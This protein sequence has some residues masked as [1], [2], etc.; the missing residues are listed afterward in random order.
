ML[1]FVWWVLLI[2]FVV[3]LLIGVMLYSFNPSP[4]EVPPNKD[5]LDTLLE[6]N[7]CVD[8]NLNNANLSGANLER[9]DLGHRMEYGWDDS[10][11]VITNLAGANLTG[12]NL[13]RADLTGA[14]LSE[15]KLSR[16][17][18]NEA[19]LGGADLTNANLNN[20]DLTY[21]KF[22]VAKPQI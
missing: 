1:A 7:E 8:C 9:T 4:Q 13:T 3:S 20:A 19:N 2:G 22:R 21:A 17:N 10:Y 5:H 14:N 15:A 16:A 6:T 18:L 12:A 11:M